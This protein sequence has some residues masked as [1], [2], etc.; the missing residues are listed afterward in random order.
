MSQRTG[1]WAL[2]ALLSAGCLLFATADAYALPGHGG[3]GHG[4]GGHGGGGHGG[5]G[6]GGHASFGG[7]H[8]GFGGGFAPSHSNFG[9][10]APNHS[11]Y[12]FA[13]SHS[14][15]GSVQNFN[16]MQ[17][18]NGTFPGSATSRSF[19]GAAAT[20]SFGSNLVGPG[21]RPPAMGHPNIMSSNISPRMTH[22]G[23]N[24][25]VNSLA[26][27]GARVTTNK[28][29]TGS[30]V[31]VAT[32]SHLS[33]NH[34]GV[35]SAHALHN[36]GFNGHHHIASA[37][38]LCA[39]NGFGNCW[40]NGAWNWCG[41][42]NHNSCFWGWG[43]GW[44]WLG[45]NCWWPS[46]YY[47]V[48]NYFYDPFCYDSGYYF[49]TA[50]LLDNPDPNAPDQIQ[51]RPVKPNDPKNPE[52]LP[53]PN[54]GPA[55]LEF[56]LPDSDAMVW[57]DDYLTETT[58]KDRTYQTPELQPGKV[59]TYRMTVVWEK[60]GQAYRDDRKVEVSANGTTTVDY[61]ALPAS[62]GGQ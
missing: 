34:V 44:P 35:N 3:G 29:A 22:V 58:G 50:P 31:G 46:W 48:Y 20:R 18:H 11:S 40:W 6:F 55:K 25:R 26:N 24:A 43:W 13:P 41:F 19:S 21:G 38:G 53:P 39:F 45:W 23:P 62:S 5:G 54:P 56:K 28:F 2:T 7:G 4:G 17:S 60:N 9:G 51:R 33:S 37:V 57:L 42:H 8:G 16:G 47:P 49:D 12:N 32:G 36:H 15:F 10:Y 52:K 14:N 30:G 61:D 1:F 27:S 59:Y